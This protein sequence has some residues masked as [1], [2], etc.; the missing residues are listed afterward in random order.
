VTFG[1][2]PG[3]A[4]GPPRRTLQAAPTRARLRVLLVPGGAPSSHGGHKRTAP[5]TDATWKKE[6][7][8]TP[9]RSRVVGATGRRLGLGRLCS[10]GEPGEPG[11]RVSGSRRRLQR[12]P[13]GGAASSEEPNG[14]ATG[15]FFSRKW[16]PS[17]AGKTASRSAPPSGLH[18]VGLQFC[19][20]CPEELAARVSDRPPRSQRARCQAG[21]RA[22]SW[23]SP[24]RAVPVRRP[25][26]L[27]GRSARTGEAA[28]VADRTVSP[29]RA[30]PRRQASAGTERSSGG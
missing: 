18:D 6:P 24:A 23:A 9:C 21:A 25:Q 26:I 2:T 11:R 5:Y 28:A 12:S 27:P 7:S 30:A 22:P 10:D 8:P 15:R 19:P 17:R 1:T 16:L 4:T 20:A 14:T 13:P 29:R 3:R